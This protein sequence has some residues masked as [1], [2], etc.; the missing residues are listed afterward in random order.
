M[1]SGRARF[2]QV[3]GAGARRRA[4]ALG[5]I[6]LLTGC[7]APAGEIRRDVAIGNLGIY[8]AGPD[9]I[10]EV[11]DIIQPG[12]PGAW[13]PEGQWTEVVFRATNTSSRSITLGPDVHLTDER[14]FAVRPLDRTA[15][16]Q[17]IS[18]KAQQ[19]AAETQKAA[20]AISFVPYVGIFGS[21]MGA[22]TQSTVVSGAKQQVEVQ[23]E[24][25]RRA[26]PAGS[27]LAPGAKLQGSVFFA[28]TPTAAKFVVGYQV[29]G[30]A[31][32]VE[33]P[34]REGG[35]AL[36]A[37]VES[38]TLTTEQ[39]DFRLVSGQPSDA[40]AFA[41]DLVRVTLGL[42]R[43]LTEEE[44]RDLRAAF[45]PASFPC[46][47]ASKVEPDAERRT[48]RFEGYPR[49][50][51]KDLRGEVRLLVGGLNLEPVT[52]AFGPR[53][54]AAAA[55]PR[56]EPASPTSISAAPPA[57]AHPGERWAVIIGIDEYRDP[58][59]APLKYASADA[60]AV[61]GF[62]IA[63][64][65]FKREN[66]ILLLNRDATEA[67]IRKALGEFLKAKALKDDEVVVYYAGHGTTE[68]DGSAEGG[69]AKYLVPWDA[70]PE[71]LY[72]TAI[73]MSRFDEIF[74]RVQARKILLIQDTCFSGGSGGTGRTFLR[75]GLATRSLALTDRFLRDLSQREG[76][77][78][79]TASD[80]NQ[81]SQELGEFKHGVFT[82]YLLQGLEGDADLDKDGAVTVRE[83][84]LYLQRRVHEKSGGN[85]TP[86]LYNV[87]DM[88]LV[89]RAAK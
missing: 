21:L 74:A 84:H 64:A 66:T 75:K 71:S 38:A 14:G 56:A 28:H 78:I 73:P 42:S 15:A 9:A 31:R 89:T 5:L 59:I 68:P 25:S 65:G 82:Y 45:S 17:G 40:L 79:L 87:G 7:A 24:M 62:L 52:Y 37:R 22:G 6:L 58:S 77:M 27:A 61:H 47:N 12:G 1:G 46:G 57:P 23:Q 83:L 13:F 88:V 85:Q 54:A 10:I 67:A 80:A 19:S 86:Q 33:V 20:T 26:I 81:L 49:G 39:G 53:G 48:I 60:K 51:L 55:V 32:L 63:R 36:L 43:A 4:L 34:L 3:R 16:A 8:A 50:C 2:D 44:I 11:L 35:R 41:A 29:A 72:S 70:D 76:R 18:L 30:E 69:L